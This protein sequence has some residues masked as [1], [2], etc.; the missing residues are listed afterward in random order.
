MFYIIAND[1]TI[2]GNKKGYK[3]VYKAISVADNPKLSVFRKLY[4]IYNNRTDKN[5]NLIYSVK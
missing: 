5:D 4:D 3:T 2:V 1:G